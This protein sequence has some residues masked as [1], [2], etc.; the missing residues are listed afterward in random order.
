MINFEILVDTKKVARAA[1]KTGEFMMANCA[2]GKLLITG[3]FIIN[4]TPEQFFSVMCKL[5]IPELGVWYLPGDNAPAES[6]RKSEIEEWE[7]RYNEQLN[8]AEGVELTNT[9]I[10]IGSS[11]IYT[12]GQTYIGIGKERLLML[13]D[14]QR[15]ECT[16]KMVLVNGLHIIAPIKEDIWRNNGFLYRLPGMDP[17]REAEDEK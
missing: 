13:G 16:G 9:F 7:Q 14:I 8:E 15:M 3:Q 4:L 1:M 5:E 11:S 6:E 10:S 2:S 12:N 17:E